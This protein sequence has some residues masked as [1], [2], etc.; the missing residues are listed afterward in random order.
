[1]QKLENVQQLQFDG[2]S[3]NEPL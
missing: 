1:M 2:Q 3:T